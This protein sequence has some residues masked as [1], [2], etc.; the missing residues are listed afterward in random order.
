ME[1]LVQFV[2]S[3]VEECARWVEFAGLS[4]EVAGLGWVAGQELGPGRAHECERMTP[5]VAVIDGQLDTVFVMSPSLCVIALQRREMAEFTEDVVEAVVLQF[6]EEVDRFV[7]AGGCLVVVVT[8]A[9]D[10]AELALAIT[11]PVYGERVLGKTQY[12][13]YP[14]SCTF[15]ITGNSPTF[16]PE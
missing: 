5:R 7:V 9:M 8:G 13:E 15:L 6:A 12:D 16:S 14:V 2:I 1:L 3:A 10:S 11:G 4:H